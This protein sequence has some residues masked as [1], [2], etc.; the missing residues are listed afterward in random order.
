MLHV[1]SLHDTHI[2]MSN[3]SVADND[4]ISVLALYTYVSFIMCVR[5]S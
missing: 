4:L 2:M 3:V 5:N 1:Y